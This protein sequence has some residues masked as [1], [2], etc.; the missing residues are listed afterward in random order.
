MRRFVALAAVLAV[1]LLGLVATVGQRTAAQDATPTIKP[2]A[3]GET[4]GL[5]GADIYYEIYG[6]GDPVVLVHGGDGTGQD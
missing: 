4:V 6:E 3:P 2:N 5:N 1:L